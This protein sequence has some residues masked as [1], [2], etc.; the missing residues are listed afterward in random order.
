MIMILEHRRAFSLLV[1]LMAA[2]RLFAQSPPASPDRLWHTP[3]E[4]RMLSDGERVRLASRF[5][6]RVRVEN[7]PADLFRVSEPAVVVIQ[8]R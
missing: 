8:G 1:I 3:D 2:S 4:R 5:P 6:V 7:S